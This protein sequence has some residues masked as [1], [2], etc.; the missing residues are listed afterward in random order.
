[1]IRREQTGFLVL[2]GHGAH[3]AA[4]DFKLRILADIILGH[5]EHAKMQ[6]GHRRERAA[7]NEYDWCSVLIAL[8]EDEAVVGEIVIWWVGEVLLG[9]GYRSVGC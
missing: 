9:G 4:H 7:G 8:I 2:V 1:M 6:V 5:L 3:V